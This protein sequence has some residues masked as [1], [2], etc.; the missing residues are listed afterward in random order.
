M[1]EV[2]NEEE[3]QLFDLQ[4]PSPKPVKE[5]PALISFGDINKSGDA[6]SE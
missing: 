4:F 5:E 2:L 6:L 3:I 1:M